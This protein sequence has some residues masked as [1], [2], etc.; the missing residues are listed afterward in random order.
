MNELT[1][2]ILE[3][4]LID[5]D[6]SKL[7]TEQKLHY[8]N[9]R[10]EQAGLDPS[11]QP[12]QYLRLNGKLV[13]YAKKAATDQLTGIHRLSCQIT[14][15]RR[16]ED[17]YVVTCRVSDPS[18]R[19]TDEMGA[20]SVKGLTGDNLCNAMMKA[21]TKAKRRAVLAHQGLGMLDETEVETIPGAE[22]VSNGNGGKKRF[23]AQPEPPALPAGFAAPAPADDD[24]EPP[25]DN[26]DGSPVYNGEDSA[27][28]NPTCLEVM[29][30]AIE[31]QENAVDFLEKTISI[32]QARIKGLPQ[33]KINKIIKWLHDH[34][35]NLSTR[36]GQEPVGCTPE[37]LKA[38]GE[39]I[40]RVT[41]GGA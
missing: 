1:P 10:C 33:P 13:L 22:R 17:A 6:L 32:I 18:A 3:S 38:L 2:E 27:E 34:N 4:V 11:A 9:H 19:F 20:V 31:S 26:P 14:D 41:A 24:A 28:D 37:T 25:P 30:K 5:G 29:D 8:Y 12:F 39:E 21:H 16:V 36:N 15:Q 35:M 23:G 40:T 7:N